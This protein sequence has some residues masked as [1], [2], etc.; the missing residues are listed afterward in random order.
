MFGYPCEKS[1][2]SVRS[3]ML[4]KMVGEDT[5][6]TTKSKVDFSKLPP[7]RDNLLPHIYRVIHKLWTY[8]G[9]DQPTF[10]KPNPCDDN[11]GWTKSGSCIEPQ[12]TCGPILPSS[13][14]VDLLEGT[15]ESIEG[16][17]ESNKECKEQEIDFDE[18]FAEE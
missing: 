6:L 15:V 17:S 5:K 2:N 7:C 9:G 10:E 8:K 3:I 16:T 12:W 1:V 13:S 18:L 4:K 14:L 11:H